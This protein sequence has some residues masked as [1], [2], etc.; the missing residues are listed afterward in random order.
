[1]MRDRF[2]LGDEVG[3]DVL[4]EIMRG[5]GIGGVAPQL[6]DQEFRV[7]DV[8]AH[9]AQ[10]H[11][12]LARHRRRVLRL[13]QERQDVVLRIDVHDAEPLG[14]LQ[15]G[16]ETPDRH[17]G[18]GLDVLLQH[19][20]VVHLVD[21]VA[22]Q[23]DHVLRRVALDDVDVLI[24]RVGRAEI[25]HGLG[26]AL[27][28]RQDVEAL[29]ALRTEEVPAPLQ[30][31]DQA[32]RLILRGDRD[33]TNA[34]VERVRQSEIDDSRFAAEIDGGLGAPVGQFHQPAAAPAR[35]HIGHGVTRERRGGR[36]FLGRIRRT[37]ERFLPQKAA[38]NA[39]CRR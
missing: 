3:N 22:R 21:M 27:R 10:R 39:L 34:R 17:V 29:V 36:R 14:F 38:A 35:E 5:V 12:R 13:L 11:V 18:A 6:L 33:A 26:N 19:L 25:P 9:A 15:R 37:H 28:G 8:D 32:V 16:L 23:D 4:A 7:E 30:M 24:D 1:M 2:A 20:F 31:P